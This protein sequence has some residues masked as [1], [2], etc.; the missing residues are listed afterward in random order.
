MFLLSWTWMQMTVGACVIFPCQDLCFQ[1]I[2]PILVKQRLTK[3][4]SSFDVCSFL[5]FSSSLLFAGCCFRIVQTIRVVVAAILSHPWLHTPT[6]FE[7]LALGLC[8]HTVVWRDGATWKLSH[9]FSSGSLYWLSSLVSV[10]LSTSLYAKRADRL[11]LLEIRP[12]KSH[13]V[14]AYAAVDLPLLPLREEVVGR[15]L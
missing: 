9:F 15:L 5:G 1:L 3:L 12:P 10:I 4:Q 8:D 11:F 14:S 2:R 6:L 7:V 13:L